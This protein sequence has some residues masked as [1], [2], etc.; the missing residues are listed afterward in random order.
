[1]T[2]R[3]LA[4]SD[5][6]DV[7]LR[8]LTPEDRP[9]A[10]FGDQVSQ[11]IGRLMGAA[12]VEFVRT[13]FAKIDGGDAT[14]AA[15]GQPS[16]DYVVTLPLLSGPDIAGV[17]V[18]QPHDLIPVDQHGRVSGMSDVYAAGDAVDFPVKQGGI[19]AQQADSVAE[20]V[21]ARYGADVEPAPFAPVLRGLLFTGDEPLYMRSD[22]PGANPDIPGAWY[23]LWWPPTKIAGRY[24]APYLF[25]RAYEDE[26]GPPPV[27]FI[28]VDVPLSEI[29]LPG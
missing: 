29:T 13:S 19:A 11:G 5:A 14:Y 3:E 27:G 26:F 15:T 6:D 23:P 16:S 2:A 17:P 4:H 1:M 10:L 20:H 7:E 25:E 8:V 22:V 18:T 12:G 28:D 9:L 21:A 24:L